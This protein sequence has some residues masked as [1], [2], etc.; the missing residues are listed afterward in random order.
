MRSG[1]ERLIDLGAILLPGCLIAYLVVPEAGPEDSL[2]LAMLLLAA[3]LLGVVNLLASA[4]LGAIYAAARGRTMNRQ[5]AILARGGR[6]LP[7]PLRAVLW[8][9]FG[10]EQNHALGRAE[11]LRKAALA[12]LQFKDALSTQGWCRALLAT[13]SPAALGLVLHAEAQARFCRALS[14]ALLWVGWVLPPLLLL[15]P[16]TLGAYLRQRHAAESLLLEAA[17]THAARQ[18][19]SLPPARIAPDSPTHAGGVVFRERGGAR[20]YLLIEAN[21]ERLQWVLPKGHIEDGE[22]PPYAAVREVREESGVWARLERE[23]GDVAYSLG[24]KHVVVRFYLM[25][26]LGQGV[27]Q[28][29]GRGQCWLPFAQAMAQASHDNTRELLAAAEAA[30]NP[31]QEARA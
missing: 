14:M 6:L 30:A 23:L 7:A 12:P 21:D 9:V 29:S 24:E 2:S 27:L 8:L 1:S 20:Q 16:L 13:E 10:E 26:A 22:H 3:A 19:A 31:A 4:A 28:E 15:L 25:R 11:R 5:I 18:G 17:I